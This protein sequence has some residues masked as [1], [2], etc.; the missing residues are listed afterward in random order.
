MNT[1]MHTPEINARINASLINGTLK[2]LRRFIS[3]P[4][5]LSVMNSTTIK[6]NVNVINSTIVI[7]IPPN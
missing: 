5:A 3:I 1:P 2:L 6:I 7:S 4:I